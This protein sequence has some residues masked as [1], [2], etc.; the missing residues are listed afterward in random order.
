[1]GHPGPKRKKF[2][3]NVTGRM[4]EVADRIL[5]GK[6]TWRSWKNQD[7]DLIGK[8]S[9]YSLFG[10]TDMFLWYGITRL[11]TDYGCSR[12]GA[13]LTHIGST[14]RKKPKEEQRCQRKQ[15][16]FRNKQ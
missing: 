5:Y 2:F 4:L 3:A 13:C 1:M 7:Y 9:D 10:R 12:R 8:K 6:A 16:S 11:D 14:E 15:P